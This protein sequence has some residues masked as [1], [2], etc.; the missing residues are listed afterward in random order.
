MVKLLHAVALHTV[1]YG[2]LI[3][4]VLPNSKLDE[5]VL[6]AVHELL[7]FGPATVLESGLSALGMRFFLCQVFILLF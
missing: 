1:G 7:A 6:K 2:F 5:L 4:D 3:A